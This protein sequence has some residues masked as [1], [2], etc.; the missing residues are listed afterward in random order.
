MTAWHVFDRVSQLIIALLE[1][2]PSKLSREASTIYFDS[3]VHYQC[4]I[5]SSYIFSLAFDQETNVLVVWYPTISSTT[6]PVRLFCQIGNL[7]LVCLQ[8]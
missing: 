3:W 5:T 7:Q 6:A 1:H 2:V 8:H 4:I